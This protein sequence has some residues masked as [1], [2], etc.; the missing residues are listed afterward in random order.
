MSTSDYEIHLSRGKFDELWNSENAGDFPFPEDLDD[1]EAAITEV[2]GEPKR[3]KK[4][5]GKA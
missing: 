5:K 2:L 4:R 1:I 3:R